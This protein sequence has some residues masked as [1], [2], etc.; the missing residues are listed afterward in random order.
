[1]SSSYSDNYQMKFDAYESALQ[2]A[3]SDIKKE[4]K[5]Y[6]GTKSE[7]VKNVKL[8][9]NEIVSKNLSKTSDMAMSEYQDLKFRMLAELDGYVDTLKISK[10][11]TN[12][13]KKSSK[14]KSS[15]KRKSSSKKK[16]KKKAS[17]KRKSKKKASSKKKSKR[18]RKIKSRRRKTNKGGNGEDK[19]SLRPSST[20]PARHRDYEKTMS[21]VQALKD[22]VRGV[23]QSDDDNISFEGFSDPK[24]IGAGGYGSIYIYFRLNSDGIGFSKSNVN[25]DGRRVILTSD[26]MAKKESKVQDIIMELF[27]V[28]KEG[29]TQLLPKV[30]VL[31]MYENEGEDSE[32]LLKEVL[33]QDEKRKETLLLNG[34]I[35]FHY[36]THDLKGKK[37]NFCAMYPGIADLSAYFSRSGKYLNDNIKH[38]NFNLKHRVLTGTFLRFLNMFY[39]SSESI[40]EYLKNLAIKGIFHLDVKLQNIIVSYGDD[41]KLV[42]QLCDLGGFSIPPGIVN[43][44]R[45]Y[46]PYFRSIQGEGA[47][48]NDVIYGIGILVL[49]M[50]LGLLHL[51]TKM[52]Y[53]TSFWEL[54]DINLEDLKKL[55]YLIYN[56]FYPSEPLKGI[57][58]AGLLK[59]TSSFKDLLNKENYVKIISYFDYFVGK[60]STDDP[61][62]YI[63]N[64]KKRN[65]CY[66][67]IRHIPHM[68]LTGVED[69]TVQAINT[70]EELQ[71]KLDDWQNYINERKNVALE[72]LTHQT[73]PVVNPPEDPP[74]K[75]SGGNW[76][77]G[78]LIDMSM[79]DDDNEVDGLIGI[80]GNELVIPFTK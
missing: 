35:P 59:E 13:K 25:S 3:K 20:I 64:D 41:G 72:Q 46:T 52:K 79:I 74:N 29:Q 45:T 56:Q 63:D 18:R 55:Y 40:K 51:L 77:D 9:L 4:M 34:V 39:K 73:S 43:A 12:R 54:K 21:K 36:F 17:S 19:K 69:S 27:N 6:S 14:K 50:L 26:V 38:Q 67:L 49:Q 8:M 30:F 66:I 58:Q 32:L 11:K 68:L 28:E 75:Q 16:S 65:K 22:A 61:L 78:K 31:K 33:D 37:R 5:A 48:V 23:K 80:I 57:L 1:M 62:S 53:P 42:Y 71:N 76:D 2:K 47:N 7:S 70:M 44:A 24:R 15:S 10:K 60:F